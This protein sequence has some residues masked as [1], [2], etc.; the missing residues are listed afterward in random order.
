MKR[1]DKRRSKEPAVVGEGA[2]RWSTGGGALPSVGSRRKRLEDPEEGKKGKTSR[3]QEEE[4]EDQFDREE[5]SVLPQ[6]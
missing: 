5:K 1:G 2:T 6:R 4:R 3:A